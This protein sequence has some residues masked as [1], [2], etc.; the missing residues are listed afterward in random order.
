MDDSFSYSFIGDKNAK[1][2]LEIGS[3]FVLLV[4]RLASEGIKNSYFTFFI[5]FWNEISLMRALLWT[6]TPWLKCANLWLLVGNFLITDNKVSL[7]PCSK[8]RIALLARAG[9]EFLLWFLGLGYFLPCRW[10]R[11]VVFIARFSFIPRCCHFCCTTTTT[12]VKKVTQMNL[13]ISLLWYLSKNY[14]F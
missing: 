14:M 10:K 2:C 8:R 6:G 11:L 3:Y 5:S 7:V 4:L 1:I 13:L 12:S 9:A